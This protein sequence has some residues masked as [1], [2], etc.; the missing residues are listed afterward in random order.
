MVN[1]RYV[2][3]A[4]TNEGKRCC[5]T[6]A[7]RG[8]TDNSLF[9]LLTHR[10]GFNFDLWKSYHSLSQYAKA[11]KDNPYGIWL[12]VPVHQQRVQNGTYLIKVLPFVPGPM[13]KMFA[14]YQSPSTQLMVGAELYVTDLAWDELEALT[15]KKPLIT[16]GRTK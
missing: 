2:I 3:C 11:Y 1:P 12:D 14:Y 13:M 16:R 10:A 8:I 7:W 15:L 9:E 6:H 5:I 4:V